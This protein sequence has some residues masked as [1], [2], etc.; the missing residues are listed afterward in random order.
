MYNYRVHPHE[1]SFRVDA[2]NPE[3]KT[4][5]DIAKAINDARVKNNILRRLGVTVVRAG[6]G[7]KIKA[8]EDGSVS[9]SRIEIAEEGPDVTHIMAYMFA[10]AGAAAVIVI[11]VTLILIRRHDK[12]RDKLGGLQSG[13]SGAESCTKDYQVRVLTGFLIV[14]PTYYS[15]F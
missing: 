13:I 2:N 7:D 15:K 4:A 3:K 6:V 9:A 11:F 1:V 12:K 8:D 5:S 14:L 10:G